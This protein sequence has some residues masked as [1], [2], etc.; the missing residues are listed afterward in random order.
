MGVDDGCYELIY[1]PALTWSTLSSLRCYGLFDRPLSVLARQY[2]FV[3]TVLPNGQQSQIIYFLT[4]YNIA[5]FQRFNILLIFRLYGV[6]V[7][8][9]LTV[10]WQESYGNKVASVLCGLTVPQWRC[11]ISSYRPCG[12]RLSR[13]QVQRLAKLTTQ[14]IQIVASW[15][16]RRSGEV[17]I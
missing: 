2:L 13:K 4:W 7:C 8:K 3:S 14:V 10:C 16:W 11:R 15:L 1:S 9:W 17:V 6:L 12:W 5:V